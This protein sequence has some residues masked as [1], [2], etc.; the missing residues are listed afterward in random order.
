MVDQLTLGQ[1]AYAKR[2]G[3]G[4]GGSEEKKTREGRKTGIHFV[5]RG[6]G[7]GFRLRKK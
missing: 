7:G 2:K 5:H 6:K 3:M 1:Q 4:K